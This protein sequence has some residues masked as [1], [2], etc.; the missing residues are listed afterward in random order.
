MTSLSMGGENPEAFQLLQRISRRPCPGI[1]GKTITGRQLERICKSSFRRERTPTHIV[2]EAAS[3][4]CQCTCSI[5]VIDQAAEPPDT[6]L[7]SKAI[8]LCQVNDGRTGVRCQWSLSTPGTDVRH[9]RPGLHR[10]QLVTIPQ[11][12]NPRL[13]T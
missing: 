5:P 1:G 3:Q 2:I 6:T 9:D 12:D 10:G 8:T 4:Q 13:G 7:A 11:Q